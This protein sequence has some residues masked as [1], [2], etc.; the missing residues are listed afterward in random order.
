MQLL[1]IWK[2]I[3]EIAKKYL[4][5]SINLFNYTSKILKD[6]AI[7]IFLCTLLITSNYYYIK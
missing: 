4:S 7:I 3:R 5:N 2:I 6:N 1:F